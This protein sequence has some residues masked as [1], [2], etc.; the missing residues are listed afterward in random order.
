MRSFENSNLVFENQIVKCLSFYGI[1]QRKYKQFLFSFVFVVFFFLK[2]PVE[3]VQEARSSNHCFIL[4]DFT[5]PVL[6]KDVQF[7]VQ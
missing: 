2:S 1:S 6:L 5:L 4:S 7:H 3:V